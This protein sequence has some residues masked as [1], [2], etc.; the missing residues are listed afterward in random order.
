MTL[1]RRRIAACGVLL[2]PALMIVFGIA[3]LWWWC[4]G[5]VIVVVV[6]EREIA[7][8]GG[9]MI[10]SINNL[11]FPQPTRLLLVSIGAL[12]SGLGRWEHLAIG[13]SLVAAVPLVFVA[14]AL[15]ILVRRRVNAGNR[16]TILTRN[17][18]E[19][20]IEVGPLVRY[21]L[22]DQAPAEL[23][24]LLLL[25]ATVAI[26][27]TESWWPVAAATVIAVVIIVVATLIAYLA[28]RGTPSRSQALSR[29]KAELA[30][31]EPKVLLY[32]P[33]NDAAVYQADMW[34]ETLES[35]DVQA[36]VVLRKHAA[37]DALAPTRLPVVSIP[38]TEDFLQIGF[39]SAR[40]ALYVT[41]VGANLHLL[42]EPHIRSTFIGHGD[43]DK[44]ASVNPFV[45]VYDEIWV[46]GEAG[47]D[48]YRDA[49]IGVREVAMVEV[50]RPQLDSLR[51]TPTDNDMPTVLYAPTW[52]GWNKSQEYGSVPH[53]GERLVGAILQSD[54][55][56]RLIYKPHPF[57]GRRLP[58]AAA[59]HR[60]IVDAIGTAGPAR[61]HRVVLPE[62]DESLLDC[63]ADA[64]FLITD[65]SSVLTDF[66]ATG[67][68]FAVCNTSEQ[69]EI[70]FA[71]RVPAA[72]AGIVL[73]RDETD[74]TEM[75]GVAGG[76]RP[77]EKRDARERVRRY[78][79]GEGPAIPRF[80]LALDSLLTA[81]E[82]RNPRR[83]L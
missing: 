67:R 80:A 76:T 41:N 24:M 78:L 15:F 3:G 42:R 5:S 6:A 22:R 2:G 71:A 73:Q 1:D 25:P 62:D 39:S 9:S 20:R 63:F 70:E 56:L 65:V 30:V 48:R 61:R 18:A 68:P 27:V 47:K 59:A 75:I 72:A 12:A 11:G 10:G 38:V 44:N 14:R 57:V 77:D 35:L 37:I 34:I 81:A 43:S 29:L 28:A 58:G 60:R 7:V 55:P 82:E 23:A 8:N 31:V 45:K 17:M 36:M 40:V 51:T 21:L 13:L 83:V 26:A 16:A 69:N 53:Q 46:A 4:L 32:F 49:D 54:V 52:D 74:F 79:M 33:D 64:D 19:A 50:G 66:V